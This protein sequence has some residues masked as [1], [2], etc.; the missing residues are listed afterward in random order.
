MFIS[1]RFGTGNVEC[2][3]PSDTTSTRHA[4]VQ[5]FVSGNASFLLTMAEGCGL[6]MKLGKINCV[7]IVESAMRSDDDLLALS[8]AFQIGD[9]SELPVLR[10]FLAGSVEERMLHSIKKSDSLMLSTLSKGT[11]RTCDPLHQSCL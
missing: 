2:V 10:L 11:S 4:T 8:R 9:V 5:R 1:D 3:S 6:G 7:V